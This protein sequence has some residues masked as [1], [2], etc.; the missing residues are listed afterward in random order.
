MYFLTTWESE[1][2]N[3]IRTLAAINDGRMRQ[4]LLLLLHTGL[5][6]KDFS[7]LY[8]LLHVGLC[9]HC[10]EFFKNII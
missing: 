10:V 2:K 1:Y 3:R 4:R 6:T 9:H 8:S 7:E 5:D